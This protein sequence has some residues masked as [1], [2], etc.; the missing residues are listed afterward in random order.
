[1]SNVRKP[2]TRIKARASVPHDRGGQQ[3]A[4]NLTPHLIAA[5][6]PVPNSGTGPSGSDDPVETFSDYDRADA[7]AKRQC[8]VT[9]DGDAYDAL[10]RIAQIGISSQIMRIAAGKLDAA[11]CYP[12]DTHRAMQLLKAAGPVA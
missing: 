6:G 5:D 3:I 7:H 1:M 11:D 2:R 8:V 10:I 9:L 12:E 4:T